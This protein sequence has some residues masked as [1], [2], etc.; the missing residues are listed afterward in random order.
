MTGDTRLV[1]V[2]SGGWPLKA[3]IAA[4]TRKDSGLAAAITIAINGLIEN[5]LYAQTLE[6]WNVSAEAVEQSQAN[7]PGLP[8]T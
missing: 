3:E 8:K 1:G 5:G 6:R 7:P 4:T 2:Q